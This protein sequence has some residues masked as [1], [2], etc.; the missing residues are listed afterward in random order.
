MEWIGKKDS[1]VGSLEWVDT[2]RKPTGQVKAS[3]ADK[4]RIQWFQPISHK[5]SFKVDQRSSNNLL[6]GMGMKNVRDGSR[7]FVKD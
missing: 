2:L 6:S 4:Q 7:Q 1:Q 3:R 5:E